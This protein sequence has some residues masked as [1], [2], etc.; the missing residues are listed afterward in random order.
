[1]TK[2][3]IPFTQLIH[4]NL[5]ILMNFCFARKPLERLIDTKFSGEWKY[6]RKGL[7]TVAENRAE[8]A[9]L[10]LAMYLRLLDDEEEISNYLRQ[11]KSNV[12]FGQLILRE[13]PKKEKELELRDVANKII[14]ASALEWNLANGNEPLLIC[15]SREEEKWVRAEI[16]IISL[17]GFCGTL[18]H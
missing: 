4:E 5:S 18:M 13:K 10:E 12:T 2:F 7:F 9:C 14:H 17:A 3:S 1:M 15:H 8:K 6:L 16:N 11:T